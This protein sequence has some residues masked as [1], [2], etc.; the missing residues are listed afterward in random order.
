MSLTLSQY[1]KEVQQGTR[2]PV[3]TVQEY[4]QRAQLQDSY[5]AFVRLHPDYV[6][7]YQDAFASRPL[8]AAPLAIKDIFMTK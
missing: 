2:D 1:I 5:N 6:A 4:L 3:A 7:A 8:A